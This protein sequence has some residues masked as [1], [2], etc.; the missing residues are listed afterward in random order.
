MHDI[1]Y[2]TRYPAILQVNNLKTMRG[3]GRVDIVFERVGYTEDDVLE[4]SVYVYVGREGE[5]RNFVPDTAPYGTS[6]SATDSAGNTRYIMDSVPDTKPDNVELPSGVSWAD[7]KTW[8]NNNWS[9]RFGAG[10]GGCSSKYE[11]CLIGPSVPKKTSDNRIER[12]GD[13]DCWR[14]VVRLKDDEAVEYSVET[15]S[16]LARTGATRRRSSVFK[17]LNFANAGS[18]DADKNNSAR[19]IYSARNLESIK[20]IDGTEAFKVTGDDYVSAIQGNKS[21]CYFELDLRDIFKARLA[22]IACCCARPQ[23]SS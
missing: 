5:H 10:S 11:S 14:K 21:V 19:I 8:Y 2:G 13:Y 9:D 6:I 17:N 23:S 1:S 16:E 7:V 12:S 20:K 18:T 15:G 4:S 22:Y 3:W